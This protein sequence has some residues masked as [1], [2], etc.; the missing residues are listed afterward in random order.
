M[1]YDQ[2]ADTLEDELECINSLG[3][4]KSVM[5]RH[6][7]MISASLLNALNFLTKAVCVSAHA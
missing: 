6:F 4:I 3:R 5:N 2:T 1:K 7:F